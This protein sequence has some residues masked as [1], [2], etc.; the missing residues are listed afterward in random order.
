MYFCNIEK[1]I[2]NFPKEI[3]S[4]KIVIT[5]ED[6]NDIMKIKIKYQINEKFMMEKI[7][8][9]SYYRNKTLDVYNLEI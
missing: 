2:N 5:Q 8:I 9:E 3:Q 6:W 4:V 1:D 7:E